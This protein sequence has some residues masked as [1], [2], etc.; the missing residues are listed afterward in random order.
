MVILLFTGP[1]FL[2]MGLILSRFPPRKINPLF[3]Y[4]TRRSMRDQA[5]WNF[6]QVV[7]SREMVKAGLVQTLCGLSGLIDSCNGHG[8][9]L[10]GVGILLLTV[11]VMLIRVERKLKVFQQDDPEIKR[12]DRR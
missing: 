9:V 12:S 6:A 10:L 8:F 1:L 5:S 11:V 3:G 7:S 2:I 4:R